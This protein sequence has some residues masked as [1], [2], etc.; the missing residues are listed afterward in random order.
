M[1]LGPNE[2]QEPS[3]QAE[4][5]VASG[6]VAVLLQACGCPSCTPCC[7]PAVQTLPHVF[8]LSPGT[9]Q[10]YCCSAAFPLEGTQS[11]PAGQLSPL[12]SL[13]GLLR[14]GDD[15]RNVKSNAIG[16]NACWITQQNCYLF[17]IMLQLCS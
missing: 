1:G 10:G 8:M 15:A 17:P 11:I 7:V 14:D 12:S 16:D 2:G 9:C 6:A 13:C 4:P 5:A 3:P